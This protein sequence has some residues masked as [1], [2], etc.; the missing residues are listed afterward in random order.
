[1]RKLMRKIISFTLLAALAVTAPDVGVRA[2]GTKTIVLTP[3]EGQWKYFGQTRTFHADEHYFLSEETT[4]PASLWELGIESEA[5]GKHKYVL[6]GTPGQGAE[7]IKLADN[8]PEFEVR[9]YKTSATVQEETKIRTETGSA[10]IAA[11]D[12]YLISADYKNEDGWGDQL[13]TEELKEGSNVITYYLRS[14]KGDS[15]RRAIDQTPKTTVI[16][17]DFTK[18]VI[19]SLVGLNSEM[20][21]MAEAGIV[22]NE[23]GMFYYMVVPADY[24]SESEEITADYIKKNVASNYGIVGYGRVEKD[25]ETALALKGLSPQTEYRIYAY[26]E[27]EAGNKSDVVFSQDLFST[28]KMELKGDVIISGTPAVDSVVKAEPKFESV[29]TGEVTYQWY[30]IKLNDD[31]EELEETVDESGGAKEDDLVADDSDDEEDADDS[32]DDDSIETDS[33]KKLADAGVE[34]TT[35]DGAELITGATGATYKVTREDIGCRLIAMV[36]ASNYSGYIAGSSGTFVPKL[37]PAVTKP[38]ISSAVY[39]PTRTL[40]AVRLPENWSW[41][42]SSIVPVYG[43]SGYRAKYVPADSKVYKSVIIRIPVPVTKRTMKK[44]MLRVSKTRAYT[45]KAIKDN[46]TL[47]DSGKEIQ[48][49]DYKVSFAKNKN[50]GKA[51]VTVKGRGNY[52]G[53]VKASFLIKTR[54]VK[55]VT[56]TYKK[57]KAYKGM[58]T[59]VTAGLVLKNGKVKMKKGRDYTVIYKNN[60][61]VGKASIFIKGK[62]N[63]KGKRTL[64]FTIVPAA[65][66]VKKLKKNKTTLRVEFTSEQKVSGYYVYVSTSASFKKSKTSEYITSGNRFGVRGLQKKTKYYVRVKAYQVK[67][68]KVYAGG[69]SKAKKVS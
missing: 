13:E 28:N 64:H 33:V 63:Y 31:A 7:S 55:S 47:K 9:E 39:S 30:R 66:K 32:E 11:P 44:S 59:K 36:K 18:P 68:G 50:P 14:N 21:T 52:T 40:S 25:K 57:T 8:A 26:M 35:V 67:K 38:V 56:C 6:K 51:T 48:K 37:M 60:T 42:D 58:K 69:Y 2:E 49:T 12:E 24:F 22:G 41:V 45:G 3:F 5:V 15:T 10:I 65:P 20:D 54:S 23:A 1:M 16:R 4:I 27:D 17:T 61:E 53:T 43:N 19:T 62:G 46:Y 34:I 29:D